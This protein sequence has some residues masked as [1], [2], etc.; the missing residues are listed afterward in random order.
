MTTEERMTLLSL[1]EKAGEPTFLRDLAEFVLQRLMEIEVEG[2]CGASRYDRNDE[3]SNYRNGYRDR[4]LETRL[5][6]LELKVPKLRKGSYYPSFLEPRK[7]AEKALVA[8]VQEAYVQGVSTRRVDELV[9]AMG[10][11]GISKSQ[12]SRLCAEIDE[13]VRSF[14]DRPLVGEWPFL[15]LDATYLKVRRAGQIISVAAIVAVAVNS[16]GQREILGLK[17]GLS[18][19]EPFWTDFLRSLVGRGLSGVRLVISDA[20]GGLKAAIAKVLGATWQR[21]RVHFMRNILACVTKSHTD[22]VATLVRTVFAQEDLEAARQHWRTVADS[23]RGKFKE[24][25]KLMDDAEEDVLA[26]MGFPDKLRRQIHSTNTIERLNREIKRRT[27]VVG[28]FPNE[29]AILRL[30]GAVLM[31]INDDWAVSRRYMSIDAIAEAMNFA[32]ENPQQL[33]KAA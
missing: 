22:M 25:A 11:S 15:W 7:T 23:L 26:F 2:H 27:D 19:A 29:D 21:C 32:D 20:H 6:T 31:E 4:D 24:A 13:R 18:E 33:E 9:Q 8:V 30:A 17:V 12:V 1:A 28:I 16:Q 5:G 10:M 14:L 3:R